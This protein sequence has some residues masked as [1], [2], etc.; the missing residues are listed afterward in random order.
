MQGDTFILSCLSP[1][2]AHSTACTASSQLSGVQTQLHSS[3]PRPPPGLP[4]SQDSTP[5]IPLGPESYSETPADLLSPP[6]THQQRPWKFAPSSTPRVGHTPQGAS[7]HPQAGGTPGARGPPHPPGWPPPPLAHRVCRTEAGAELQ[8]PW[9]PGSL[10]GQGGK[11]GESSPGCLAPLPQMCSSTASQASFR[12]DAAGSGAHVLGSPKH[13]RGSK[14]RDPTEAGA[15]RRQSGR[16]GEGP[17]MA[18]MGW[19]AGLTRLGNQGRVHS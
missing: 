3:A 14:R 16:Q 19:G 1:D 15:E 9:S 11:G 13:L 18:S 7:H 10:P 6:R 8:S 12:G 5:S 17:A 2:P 4:W